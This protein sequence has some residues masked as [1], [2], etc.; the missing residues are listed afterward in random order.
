MSE[1]TPRVKPTKP[2]PPYYVELGCKLG[3]DGLFRHEYTKPDGSL[4]IEV[5]VPAE[6]FHRIRR[7]NLKR[8]GVK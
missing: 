7:E 4:G 8:L 2:L 1:D 3:R 6:D 5:L